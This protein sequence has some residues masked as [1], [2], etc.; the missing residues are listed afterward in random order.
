MRITASSLR[1]IRR[2]R[3]S[4]FPAA[5]S[6]RQPAASFTRGT[7]NGQSSLPMTSVLRSFPWSASRQRLGGGDREDLAVAAGGRRIGR[8]DQLLPSGPKMATSSSTSRLWPPRRAPARRLPASRMSAACGAAARARSQR[9]QSDQRAHAR[10]TRADESSSSSS[11]LDRSPAPPSATAR[12]APAA[13]SALAGGPLGFPARVARERVRARAAPLARPPAPDSRCS[14]GPPGSRAGRSR[15]APPPARR[16][17]VA[18]AAAC[19]S[20]RF[21]CRVCCP[22]GTLLLRRSPAR[23]VRCS[24]ACWRDRPALRQVFAVVLPVL[25]RVLAIV[26]LVVPRVVVHV[27]AAVPAV[28]P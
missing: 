20:G 5:V 10:H 13:L 12:A 25:A 18:R 21:S 9:G 22:L 16:C 24:C 19:V 2:A 3:T 14:R 26:V 28:G 27:A 17:A 6:N 8:V 1:P 4:S 23:S 11:G 7:G 15:L